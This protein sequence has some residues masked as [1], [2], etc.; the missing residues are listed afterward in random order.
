MRLAS[1]GEGD[2]AQYCVSHQR[3]GAGEEQYSGFSA[4]QAHG[5]SWGRGGGLAAD[6]WSDAERRNTIH[7]SNA[8]SG[9][10]A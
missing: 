2:L 9:R 8:V 10:N 4:H 3:A 6:V 1:S 7:A 5:G